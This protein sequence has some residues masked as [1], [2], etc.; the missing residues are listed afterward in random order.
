MKFIYLILL[1]GFSA[2]ADIVDVNANAG[3]TSLPHCGGKARLICTMAANGSIDTKS[4][5]AEF[6]GSKCTK[7]NMYSASTFYPSVW[8]VVENR[9][10]NEDKKIKVLEDHLSGSTNRYFYVFFAGDS[11]TPYIKMKF[12]LSK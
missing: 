7:I 8:T 6:S 3:W 10:R 11:N 4:C 5:T 12:N 9:G 2:L 1:V